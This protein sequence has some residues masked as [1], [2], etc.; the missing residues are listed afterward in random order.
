MNQNFTGARYQPG[1]DAA[2]ITKA[3]R[4]EI[5]QRIK[6]GTLP[7]GLKVSV[8][9]QRYSMGRSIDLTVTALPAGFPLVNPLHL[10]FRRDH[11]H[12]SLL[13]LPDDHP[14]I[15]LYTPEARALRAQ[16]TEIHG[17]WNFDRSDSASDY[18]CNYG[19]EAK[20]DWD[21]LERSVA[22]EPAIII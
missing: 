18:R 17:L 16:L 3:M 1:L 6:A 21:L 12:A 14:A 8:R 10:Q 15:P 13:H 9:L 19:G 22:R 11:P 2:A 5:A 20:F 7:A 4:Q